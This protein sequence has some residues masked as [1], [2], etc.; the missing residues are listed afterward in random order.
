MFPLNAISYDG[1]LLL[2]FTSLIRSSPDRMRLFVLIAETK[3]SAARPPPS[4]K[5]G[6]GPVRCEQTMNF[7][8][9]RP[10]T[11]KYIAIAPAASYTKGIIF[12]CVKWK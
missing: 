6:P 4:D 12:R 11:I 7:T 9:Y 1:S 8:R 3:T 10:I 2:I 5:D